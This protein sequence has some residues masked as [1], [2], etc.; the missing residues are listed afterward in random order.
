MAA[1]L[2]ALHNPRL[3]GRNLDFVLANLHMDFVGECDALEKLLDRP[4]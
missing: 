1:A 4:G 3:V 2:R